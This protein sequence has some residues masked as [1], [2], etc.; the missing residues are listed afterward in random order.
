[1]RALWIILTDPETAFRFK[2]SKILAV[3]VVL[4]ECCHFDEVKSNLM[5]LNKLGSK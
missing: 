4:D 2:Q 1:M 5:R 3:V